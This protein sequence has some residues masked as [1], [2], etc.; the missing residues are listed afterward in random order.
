MKEAAASTL[1]LLALCMQLDDA[2]LTALQNHYHYIQYRIE[3]T[4]RQ[5]L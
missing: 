3:M 5:V 4:T 2:N 1:M